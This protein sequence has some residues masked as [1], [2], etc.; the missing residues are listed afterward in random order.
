M[1]RCEKHGETLQSVLDG[2][3]LVFWAKTAVPPTLHVVYD[4]A[5]DVHEWALLNMDD[6]ATLWNTTYFVMVKLLRKSVFDLSKDVT[7]V[8]VY[9]YS[10]GYLYDRYEA[11]EREEEADPAV[12]AIFAACLAYAVRDG[13]IQDLRELA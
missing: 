6:G 1:N 7:D 3:S 5:D 4:I 13:V 11:P 9:G 2:G 8:D 12:V 10:L